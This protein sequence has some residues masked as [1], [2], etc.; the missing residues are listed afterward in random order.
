MLLSDTVY[1]G[2]LPSR[3]YNYL[4]QNGVFH[5]RRAHT[6]R[7]VSCLGQK[8]SFKLSAALTYLCIFWSCGVIIRTLLNLVKQLMASLIGR[9]LVP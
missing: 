8:M 4:P 1:D 9:P 6:Y 5:C 2:R 7:Q 3:T